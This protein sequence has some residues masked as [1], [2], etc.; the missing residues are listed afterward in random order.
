MKVNIEGIDINYIVEGNGPNVLLLH[1]WGAN[2]DTMMPIFN[3]LVKNF[4]VYA[5][6]FPGFGQSEE[7]SEVF[8]VYD[9]ARVAKKFIDN[10]NMDEVIL[11]GHSFGG[12]VSIVLSSQYKNLVKK[13]ILIDS[14]GLIPKRGAKYYIKV[15]SFKILRAVYN[16]LFF[17]IDKKE[18]M[19]KFYKKFGS[20]D[21][22]NS[23]GIMRK[24]LVKVV[25]E[26]LKP[27]LKEIEASTLLIWGDKD[28]ATP[29]Y[30]GKIMENEIRDSGLVVLEGAGHYSYLDSF[31]RFSIILETFLLG[32]E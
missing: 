16:I 8:G 28:T 29:L 2:I 20:T 26:D 32:G 31:G 13:M 18:R 19:E 30:M 4:R 14:A 1:G 9:Y 27:L 22:Q 11:I 15:Y 7:P 17:W 21:Y 23:S 10:F 5:I 6:D 25:N 24:V 3:L 12:R